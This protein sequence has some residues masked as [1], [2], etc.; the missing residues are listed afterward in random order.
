MV[1]AA[2]LVQVFKPHLLG[3]TVFDN[4]RVVQELGECPADFTDYAP[5]LLR[6]AREHNFKYPYQEFPPE[7]RK[8]EVA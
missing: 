3:D 7:P 1:R 4:A 8:Q 6:F 5:A 2:T